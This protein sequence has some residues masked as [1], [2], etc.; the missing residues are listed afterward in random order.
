MGQKVI[1]KWVNVYFKGGRLLQSG[2]V[3]LKWGNYF[4][5]GHNNININQTSEM[6]SDI[7]AILLQFDE[8]FF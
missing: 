2:T 1:S 4:K 3:I 5:L 6:A 8:K 7:T